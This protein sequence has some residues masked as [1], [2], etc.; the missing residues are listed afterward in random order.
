M[1]TVCV[2]GGPG[3]LMERTEICGSDG[4]ANMEPSGA[5]KW[6][7]LRR[8]SRTPKATTQ[9]IAELPGKPEQDFQE[10]PRGQRLPLAQQ[11]T[12][13]SELR[14]GLTLRP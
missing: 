10:E 8:R 5:T 14:R 13:S 6:H 3:K 11:I 9:P 4:L 12:W 7:R 1:R 2:T